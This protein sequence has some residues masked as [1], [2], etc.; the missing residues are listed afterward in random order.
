V[1]NNKIKIMKNAYF[2]YKEV[3]KM[4]AMDGEEIDQNNFFIKLPIIST[5][6]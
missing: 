1:K 4:G 3:E 2:N 6:T 5:S